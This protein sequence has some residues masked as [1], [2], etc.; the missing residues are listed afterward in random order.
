MGPSRLLSESFLVKLQYDKN[1]S[2]VKEKKRKKYIYHFLSIS[3]D[4]SFHIFSKKRMDSHGISFRK[5][6]EEVGGHGKVTSHL[7]ARN[8]SS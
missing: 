6:E 8:G 1:G 3:G 2:G 5:C 4:M 7:L